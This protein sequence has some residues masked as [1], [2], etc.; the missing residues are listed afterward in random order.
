MLAAYQSFKASAR[1]LAV[2][3]EQNEDQEQDKGKP[4]AKKAG[5]EKSSA[6]REASLFKV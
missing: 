4:T 6:H 1:E 5:S 3:E 2:K